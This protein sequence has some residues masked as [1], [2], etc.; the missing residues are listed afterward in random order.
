MT[1]EKYI[2]SGIVV[3]GLVVSMGVSMY[4]FN[5][6][7]EATRSS[8]SE[9][10]PLVTSQTLEVSG[11]LVFEDAAGFQFRYPSAIKVTDTT[12]ENTEYY[13]VLS[14][15]KGSE[16]M[17][18]EIKDSGFAS[19]DAWKAQNGGNDILVGAVTLS[20]ISAKQFESVSSLRTVAVDQGVLYVFESPLSEYWQKVQ[21]VVIS[22]F[23]FQRQ[24]TSLSQPSK[25]N[26]SGGAVI[27]EEET[28]IR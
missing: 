1:K 10:N 4:V 17:S 28:I 27:Y 19:I 5:N 26:S 21:D 9:T 11:D 16:E 13:T 2:L 22:T 15:Q 25:A 18:I 8:A 7:R 24:T 6:P 14:L 3:A 12:P 20:G 23:A